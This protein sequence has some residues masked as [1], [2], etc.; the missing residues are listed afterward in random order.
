MQLVY[1]YV[2]A[3]LRRCMPNHKYAY[4]GGGRAEEEE[5]AAAAAEAAAAAAAAADV[6]TTSSRRDVVVGGGGGGY[7]RRGGHET[8]MIIDDM[9]I[10]CDEADALTGGWGDGFPSLWQ[11]KS[12]KYHDRFRPPNTVRG[13]ARCHASSRMLRLETGFE[14]SQGSGGGGGGVGGG[15]VG[16]GGGGGSGNGTG[17]GGGG[18][19]GSGSGDR[20]G[21][22]AGGQVHHIHGSGSGLAAEF[23]GGAREGAS[24]SDDDDGSSS[25]EEEGMEM[26]AMRPMTPSRIPSEILAEKLALKERSV[27]PME[28]PRELSSL[29]TGREADDPW[30]FR[31]NGV[32]WIPDGTEMRMMDPMPE[33]DRPRPSRLRPIPSWRFKFVLACPIRSVPNA[34]FHLSPF[35][36]PVKPPHAPPHAP[37][38]A[39]PNAPPHAPPKASPLKP[40]TLLLKE[41]SDLSHWAVMDAASAAAAT[42]ATATATSSATVSVSSA[43]STVT[44]GDSEEEEEEGSEEEGDVDVDWPITNGEQHVLQWETDLL[45]TLV[46]PCSR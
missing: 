13:T 3:Y 44:A 33:E 21:G 40:S 1:R 12:G 20:R 24:S 10:T 23:F 26:S 32:G 17:G 35:N 39:P 19:G 7:A 25:S 4:G 27:L 16:G 8:M 9:V 22:G 37:S 41:D 42:A 31:R 14:T 45:A 38:H 6:A 46:G 29:S 34:A 43:T 2:T 36:S 11:T 28:R 5:A 18:G 30:A 15:G